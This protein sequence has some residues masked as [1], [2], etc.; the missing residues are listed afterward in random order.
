MGSRLTAE[1]HCQLRNC[2][3]CRAKC[4]FSRVEFKFQFWGER[5]VL[6]NKSLCICFCFT[7]NVKAGVFWKEMII[8]TTLSAFTFFKQNKIKWLDKY[9]TTYILSVFVKLGLAVAVASTKQQGSVNWG[10][11]CL[12]LLLKVSVSH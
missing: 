2:F 11:S 4:I 9:S 5:G 8:F 3:G 6:L 7:E 12:W 1:L 10:Y